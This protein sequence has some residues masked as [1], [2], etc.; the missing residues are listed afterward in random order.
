[1]P[2]ITSFGFFAIC[3]A[4]QGDESIRAFIA[5]Y[6]LVHNGRG[7]T[8]YGYLRDQGLA[9]MAWVHIEVR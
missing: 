7:L 1:M 6:R 3:T 9:V 8:P 2:D 4:L 5:R